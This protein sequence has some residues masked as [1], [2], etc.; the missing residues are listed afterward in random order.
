MANKFF[1]C[2]WFLSF[3]QALRRGFTFIE[4]ILL[5]KEKYFQSGN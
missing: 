3:A 4:Q 1:T 2:T 5:D